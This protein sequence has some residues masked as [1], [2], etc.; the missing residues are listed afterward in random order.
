MYINEHRADNGDLGIEVNCHEK[1][2][3]RVQRHHCNTDIHHSTGLVDAYACACSQERRLCATEDWRST[4]KGQMTLCLWFRRL[5]YP[6]SDKRLLARVSDPKA[7]RRTGEVP[8]TVIP[9]QHSGVS[10]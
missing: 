2:D 1:Q 4:S 9:L 7:E 8:A 5:G 3:L 10:L 6:R